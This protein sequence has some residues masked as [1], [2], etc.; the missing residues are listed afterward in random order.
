MAPTLN[1]ELTIPNARPICL[2]GKKRPT[3]FGRLGITIPREAPHRNMNIISVAGSP[4]APLRPFVSAITKQPM[5]ITLR[6][7]KRSPSSPPRIEKSA[8]PRGRAPH[9]MPTCAKVNCN[10]RVTLL[11]RTG[12]AV[13]G[14]PTAP[15]KTKLAISTTSH[16][17]GACPLPVIGQ[18]PFEPCLLS[19]RY[20]CLLSTT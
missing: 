15:I 8:T 1:P 14:I 9:I 4:Q 11:K 2:G 5:P 18:P 20:R 7:S 12:I 6:R 16:L 3:I 17:F 19:V 13:K 10:S